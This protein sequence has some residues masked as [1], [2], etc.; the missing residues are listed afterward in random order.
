MVNGVSDLSTQSQTCLTYALTYLLRHTHTFV[1][2]AF[3][4]VYSA[5]T[6]F[7]IGALTHLCP[8]VHVILLI[9]CECAQ[10][11]ICDDR[12][13]KIANAL[14]TKVASYISSTTLS[15]LRRI[16]VPLSQLD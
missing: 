11:K 15:E 7:N 4:S 5:H 9:A 16:H 10:P 12:A 13:E 14:I 3:A 8:L 2:I 6:H 1:G